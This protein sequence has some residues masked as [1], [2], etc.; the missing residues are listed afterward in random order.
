[1]P[2]PATADGRD[3]RCSHRITRDRRGRISRWSA[4]ATTSPHAAWAEETVD[5]VVRRL[6]QRGQLPAGIG[7]LPDPPLPAGGPAC[8][9]RPRSCTTLAWAISL[10]A[11]ARSRGSCTRRSRPTRGSAPA[12]STTCRTAGRKSSPAISHEGAVHLEDILRRRIPLALTDEGL[13]ASVA[14]EV[15]TR[16]VEA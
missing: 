14:R 8:R 9:S 5:R 2:L 6:R 1:M 15:A 13:G 7:R 4:R 12:S 3:R 16:L 10:N 11:T